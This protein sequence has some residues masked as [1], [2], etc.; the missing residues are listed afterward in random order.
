MGLNGAWTAGSNEFQTPI[1]IWDYNFNTLDEK[2]ST[3]VTWKL[4]GNLGGE[5]Y[6]DQVRG[7]VNEGAFYAER[8]GWHL[9]GYDTSAWRSITPVKNGV[10]HAGAGIFV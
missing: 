6:A 1:G 8:Q 7:P 4:T 5:D 9:P 2:L 3:A 10:D